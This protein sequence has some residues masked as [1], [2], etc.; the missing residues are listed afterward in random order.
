MYMANHNLNI[1]ILLAG[2]SLLVPSTPLINETNTV[3]GIGSL[4]LMA[5]RCAGMILSSAYLPLSESNK[6][7]TKVL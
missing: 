4:G 1:E 6:E 3:N 7:L 2:I 5:N